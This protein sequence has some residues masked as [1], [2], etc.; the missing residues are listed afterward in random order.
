L[1]AE[2]IIS[3]A[4]EY[5]RPPPHL[6]LDDWAD[7]YAYLSSE[8]SAESGRWR[9]LPYQRGIMKAIT[10]PHI[11][12]VTV[13][14]SARVGYTKIINHTCG[15]FMHQDP[16]PIMVVQPTDGDAEGYSKD[17]IAPMLRDTPV[18]EGLVSDPKARDSGN[19]MTLKAFPGGVLQLVGANSPRGFR[20]V[21][22]RIVIFDETDGYPQSAGTEG[23]QIKLGIKRTETYYNRKHIAGSTPTLELTS[24][25]AR[26]FDQSDQRHYF[27]PCPECDHKQVLKWANL[28]WEPGKP[29]TALYHCE[30]CGAGIPHH[31]KRGM[32]EE[33][34]RRQMAGESGIGWVA[35]KPEVKGHAGFHIWA[36]YSY[37][38][39]ATWA[40]LAAEWEACH[41]NVEELK[42]F[43]NTVLGETWKGKGDAPDWQRLYDRRENYKTN[44]LPDVPVILF[45]GA[46]VQKDRIEVEIVAYGEGC[47]SWSIDY[48]VLPGDTSNIEAPDSPWKQLDLLRVELWR[49][50]NGVAVPLRALM[51][52][53]QYN[54]NVVL[55]WVRKCPAS[56]V[57]AAR[58][59]D[60]LAVPVGQPKAVDIN[61]DGKK[62]ARGAK[63]W[64]IGV[65]LLK[66][67][68]Y[69]WLKQERPTTESG[70]D[71]PHGYCHFPEYGDEFFKQLTAE[72]VAIRIVRGY[73]RPIWQKTRDRNEALDCRVYARAAAILCGLDRVSSEQWKEMALEVGLVQLKP[74]EQQ[75]NEAAEPVKV[76]TV[77]GVTVERRKSKFW[78]R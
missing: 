23:D 61:R 59:Q 46:D 78:E 52:D 64:P 71:Y 18:L 16:C 40:H 11:E 44:T 57:F 15:Y 62:K 26:R 70:L 30:G 27:V 73:R 38:P 33:A 9:S 68:L 67:E 2:T 4:R 66:T 37:A 14:K 77:N 76:Q 24:R 69:G 8:S 12:A 43:I 28:K 63:Q 75:T 7:R 13:M 5:W 55:S 54:T 21:T 22:R 65:N 6:D 47:K 25:I 50:S 17:E 58:G 53:A 19:T 20:R 39:N 3:Q 56:Q 48:R 74:G 49:H 31:K 36:G 35:L 1:D 42:T 29:E 10:D 60:E 45:A 72:E 32:I 51:V 41:N 34:H